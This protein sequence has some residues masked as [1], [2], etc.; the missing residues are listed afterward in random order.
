[1]PMLSG[2]KVVE[3]TNM[4]TAPLCGMMLADLGAEVIKVENPKGGDLF[5]NWRGGTYSAQFGAYNRNKRSITLDIRSEAGA[6]ILKKLIDDADILLQNFR[7]G[8]MGRLGFARDQLMRR[9]PKL[10]HCSISG[11]GE[12]GPYCDRPA[13]DSVAQALSGVSS[14]FLDPEA[15]QFTGPTVV[16]NATGMYACY[17]ILGALF[18]RERTGKARHLDINMLEAGIA[19][20]PDPFAN[21]CNSGITPGPTVRV[22]ASQSFALK[23]GDGKLLAI[24]L[25]I[26]EKFWKGAVAAF[27]CPELLEDPRFAERAGRMENY[28]ELKDAF[29]KASVSQSRAYWLPR[30]DA[31]D[32]PFSPILTLNETMEDNQVRHL[33]TFYKTTHPSEGDLTLIRRPI[34]IDSSREDQ[35]LEP[36]PTLGEHTE[37]ILSELGYASEIGDLKAKGII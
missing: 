21:M 15:P 31:E 14:L 33:D 2:I 27:S 36:P 17:G 7:P 4:I 19:F 26:Q 12:D 8:V 5:R 29:Q 18:E 35:P 9:N 16:D 13:Y 1:M 22:Q 10:I 28:I 34:H 32:V 30:L 20:I 6:V 25:S 3:L 37:A 11:F 23:C 24:H